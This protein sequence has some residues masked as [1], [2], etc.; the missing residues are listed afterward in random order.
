M[1][2]TARQTQFAIR[3]IFRAVVAGLS[4]RD[5]SVMLELIEFIGEA[6]GPVPFPLPVLRE[7]QRLTDTDTVGYVEAVD[8][9]WRG[10]ETVTRPT[11]PW[12]FDNLALVGHEDPTRRTHAY[13]PTEPIAI[14]DFL[15]ARQFQKTKLYDLVCEPLG[16]ADSLHLYL[17]VSDTTTRF[18][19]FDRSRRE[20]APRTRL[21]LQ[22]LRPHLTQ[23][24][25]RWRAEAQPTTVSLPLT[26]REIEIL[27]LV[28]EGATNTAIA[29]ALWVTEHTVRKHLE[30][31]YRKLGVHNRTAAVAR[32]AA[33]PSLDSNVSPTS[34]DLN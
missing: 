30:N 5:F 32:I 23:A 7:L 14:S 16:V 15:C 17:P 24:R 1:E 34:A 33:V 26:K 31:V 8:G 12:L 29:Q 13:T 28:A 4:V 9:V 25:N 11:P 6:E 21:L 18:F 10:L 3:R 2:A 19:F 20:F 22:T 27:R